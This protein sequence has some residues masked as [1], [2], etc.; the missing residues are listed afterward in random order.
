MVNDALYLVIDMI[1]GKAA[2]FLEDFG[3]VTFAH[4]GHAHEPQAKR[5]ALEVLVI[6]SLG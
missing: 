4:V 2:L 3:A 1:A 5:V 6:L